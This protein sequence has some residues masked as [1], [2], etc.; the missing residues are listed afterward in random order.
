MGPPLRS[1]T[2][3]T[4]P[5]PLQPQDLTTPTLAR[6]RPNKDVS[7]TE[8]SYAFSWWLPEEYQVL[9]GAGLH[10]AAASPSIGGGAACGS[11]QQPAI[12]DLLGPLGRFCSEE[13]ACARYLPGKRL[14]L[15]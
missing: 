12:A 1:G 13:A 6:L 7:K 5:H 14:L 2:S 8:R 15:H 4:F 11:W 10:W 9:Q 3:L